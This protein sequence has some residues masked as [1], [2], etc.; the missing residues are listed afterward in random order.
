MCNIRAAFTHQKLD[1]FN[2]HGRITIAIATN[3]ITTIMIAAMTT[4]IM[5]MIRMALRE[6]PPSDRRVAFAKARERVDGGA[7]CVGGRYDLGV[8][9]SGHRHHSW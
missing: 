8:R 4:I 7:R 9:E 2:Q 3:T 6:R 5:I 1:Q